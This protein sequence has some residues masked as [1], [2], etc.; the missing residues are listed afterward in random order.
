M[1]K[2]RTT[3]SSISERLAEAMEPKIREYL[4]DMDDP[5]YNMSCKSCESY[6]DAMRYVFTRIFYSKKKM[7]EIVAHTY[8]TAF[9][10][11]AVWGIHR[12]KVSYADSFGIHKE[13]YGTKK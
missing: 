5:I 1:E 10:E 8:L 13:K 3:F 4:K 12:T 9:K 6:F 2:H 7:R 11:G